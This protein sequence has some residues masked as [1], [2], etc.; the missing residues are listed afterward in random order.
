M[1]SWI[2]MWNIAGDVVSP[3]WTDFQSS[4]GLTQKLK[5]SLSKLLVPIIA[6]QT[7]LAG[8]IPASHCTDEKMRWVIGDTHA[9]PPHAAGCRR[10]DFVYSRHSDLT[11]WQ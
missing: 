11:A 1:N 7:L 5:T 10:T 8:G 9:S 2:L 4:N 6:K 3:Y